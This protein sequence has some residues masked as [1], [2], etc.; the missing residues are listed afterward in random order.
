M[1]GTLSQSEKVVLQQQIQRALCWHPLG[2]EVAVEEAVD[3]LKKVSPVQPY[4]VV[5]CIMLL[6]RTEG[7]LL[8]DTQ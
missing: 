7:A 5:E 6:T 8:W 2:N 4:P 1:Q 3:Y